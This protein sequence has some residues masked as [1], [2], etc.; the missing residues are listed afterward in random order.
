MS[1]I[2]FKICDISSL[3]ARTSSYV[4]TS[5]S[6]IAASFCMIE[7]TCCFPLTT[8]ILRCISIAST[9][10]LSFS[11]AMAILDNSFS[12]G[13]IWSLNESISVTRVFVRSSRM[14]SIVFLISES[15]ISFSKG[16]TST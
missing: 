2:F 10:R 7:I 5:C 13:L 8:R 14:P 9:L 16:A 1:P 6:S 4:F 15:G 12:P 3:K 11:N